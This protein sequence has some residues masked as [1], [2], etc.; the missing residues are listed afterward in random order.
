MRRSTDTGVI[1]VVVVDD[2]PRKQVRSLLGVPVVGDT[3]SLAAVVA[4]FQADEVF[5]AVPSADQ[6]LTR[7]SCGRPRRPRCRSRSCPRCAS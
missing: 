1:P 5:L 2:D 4:H 6:Q 7:R 3:S